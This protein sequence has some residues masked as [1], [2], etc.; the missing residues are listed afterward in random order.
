MLKAV[1]F[2]LWGTLMT[3]AQQGKGTRM[4]RIRR[5]EEALREEKIIIDPETIQR[6][7]ET[8]GE[9][10]AVLWATLRDIGDRE[11]VELLLDILRADEKIS[12]SD[13]LLDPLVEAYTHP[14]L[15]ELPVPL[16][17]ASDVLSTL[18]ARG[19]R[20]AVICNTGRTPGKILRIILEQMG[21]AKYLS[22]QTFSDEVGLRKPHLEIFA[23]TLRALGVEAS[24]TVHVGD[25]L[26]ADI[27][28]ARA[29]GMRAVHLCHAGGADPNPGNWE[30]ISSLPELLPLIDRIEHKSR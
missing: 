7:Y 22:V 19:M 13:S 10:L 16:D 30:T 18:E 6:A 5:I 8:V 25:T 23:R 28:G 15:S 24:E 21:L 12:I 14:I 2:D 17:G 4:E 9:R 1:T 3:E 29:M 27:A 20:L 11:Q 26:A